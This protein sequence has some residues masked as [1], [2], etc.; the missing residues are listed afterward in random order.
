MKKY[1]DNGFVVFGKFFREST[2]SYIPDRV[3][4]HNIEPVRLSLLSLKQRM[5]TA[6]GEERIRLAKEGIILNKIILGM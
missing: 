4:D 2:M 1:R 6:E 3:F 5:F